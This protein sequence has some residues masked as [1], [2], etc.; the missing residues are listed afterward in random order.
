MH[1]QLII[2]FSRFKQ[3][4][5]SSSNRLDWRSPYFYFSKRLNKTLSSGNVVSFKSIGCQVISSNPKKLLTSCEEKGKNGLSKL[6]ILAM[7]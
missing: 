1:Y 4:F 2:K 5:S 3:D 7:H 6:L